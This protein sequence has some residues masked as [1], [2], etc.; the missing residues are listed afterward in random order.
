MKF[1]E[2]SIAGFGKIINSRYEFGDGLNIITGHNEAGKSTLHAC[3]RA[4][5]YG[6]PRARG[7]D[8]LTDDY[9]RNKPWGS[10]EYAAGLV[11]EENGHTYR[12]DR[13]F[14][15]SPVDAVITDETTGERIADPEEFLEEL[16]CGLSRKGFD[17]TV[18]IGQLRCPADASVKNELKTYIVNLDMT[19]SHELDAAR[20]KRVLNSRKRELMSGID[21]DAARLYSAN[22]A[23]MKELEARLSEK[24][25][26]DRIPE[27]ESLFR[28]M[29]AKAGETEIQIL[30]VEGELADG[31]A[32]LARTGIET[33]EEAEKASEEFGLAKSGYA[34]L[35]DGKRIRKLTGRIAVS[36]VLFVIAAGTAVYAARY[37]A[38]NVISMN[39]GLDSSGILYACAGIAVLALIML[40]VALFLRTALKKEGTAAQKRLEDALER[41]TGNRAIGEE[42]IAEAENNLEDLKKTA[43]DVEKN[44]KELE[45]LRAER[46]ETGA[47]S[48]SCSEDIF[49]ARE[50]K[51]SL[52][53]TIGEYNRLKEERLSPAP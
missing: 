14:A 19:G 28:T 38:G 4:M 1:K 52:I 5:L 18:S 20:A 35:A 10:P 23:R 53:R 21:P 37:G 39:T 36:A 25:Y 50:E 26:T 34:E 43:G 33:F 29:T 44:I 41:F 17:N 8:R 24:E 47:K 51:N 42:N 49:R 48:A 7:I 27:L 11:I 30:S 9:S 46:E 15:E 16:L 31:K 3:L 32:Q 6:M 12:I 2:L 45:N 22:T 13:N 40:L